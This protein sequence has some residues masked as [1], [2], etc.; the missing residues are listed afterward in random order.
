MKQH[1]YK[2]ITRQL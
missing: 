1:K 2:I